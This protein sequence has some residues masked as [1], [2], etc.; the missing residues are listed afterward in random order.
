[1]EISVS[2]KK[3][4]EHFKE[5]KTSIEYSNDMKDIYSSIEENNPRKERKILIVLD[6]MIVDLISDEKT[7]PP[8]N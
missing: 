8:S 5:S 2:D 7:S 4:V 1:M 6:Y 3:G